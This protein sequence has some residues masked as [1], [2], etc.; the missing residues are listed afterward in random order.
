MAPDTGELTPDSSH[1]RAT[2]GSLP[3]RLTLVISSLE[4]GGAERV[5]AELAN[6]WVARGWPITMVQYSSSDMEP[7]FALDPRVK[8]VRLGLFRVS[9]W[10]VSA[11]VNNLRRMLALGRA[12][13]ATRPDL[14]LSFMNK[15]N[16]LTVLSMIGSRVPVIV[17]EHTAPEGTIN[18]P[19]QILRELAYRRASAVVMLTPD[20]LARMSPAIRRRGRVIPNPLPSTFT[21]SEGTT[22]VIG[23]RGGP[24]IIGLGRLTPEKG[25]DLLIEAFAQVATSWPDARLIIWGEGRD[26]EHLEQLRT[27]Y[28]LVDRVDLP[29][30]TT[31]PEAVMRVATIFVLSSRLEGLPVVLIEAMALGR[32]V[33]AA[34]CDFGP[35]DIVRDG[36]DGLLVPVEDAAAI[37]AAIDRLLGDETLRAGLARRALEVRQR[38]AMEAIAPQW[39]GLFREVQAVR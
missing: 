10:K 9:R 31:A 26:R 24:V 39:E 38:F 3:P 28:G 25:F 16:V 34:D 30:S 19:W 37:A 6:H 35:R 20:A 22:A 33:I 7:V 23:D 8:Q 17:S 1:A 5:M 11:A 4:M 18:R 27:R 32:A 36:L 12:I 13:R 21:A 2:T 29:G 15:T 14:V